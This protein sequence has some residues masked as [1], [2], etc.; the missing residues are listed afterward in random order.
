MTDKQKTQ[1]KKDIL[2]AYFL[3][4]TNLPDGDCV[5]QN[6]TTQQIAD[7]LS[8]MGVVTQDDIVEYMVAHDFAPTT[9][10]DGTVAWAIWRKKMI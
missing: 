9:E 3:Q 2:D 6:R 10:E 5:Q 4:R 1:L 8:E 7:E